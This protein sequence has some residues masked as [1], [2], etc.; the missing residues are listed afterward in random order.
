LRGL[1][2]NDFMGFFEHLSKGIFLMWIMNKWLGMNVKPWL[3]HGA[4]PMRPYGPLPQAAFSALEMMKAM[5]Y[6]HEEWTAEAKDNLKRALLVAIPGYYG[7]GD[8]VKLTRDLTR[9]IPY[10]E[11][12]T[13]VFHYEKN[14]RKAWSD[15]LGVTNY[16]NERDKMLALIDQG[17]YEAANLIG[18]RWGIARKSNGSYKILGIRGIDRVKR[19]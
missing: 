4:M 11:E 8:F 1:V 10:A 19:V 13:G 15:F 12:R 14:R 6:G 7:V 2:R 9:E 18:E 5:E 16:H 3:L 17:E